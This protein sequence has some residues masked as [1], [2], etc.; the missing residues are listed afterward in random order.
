MPITEER[1]LP[2]LTEEAY[3]IRTELDVPHVYAKSMTDLALVQGFVMAQDR[4]VQIELTRR[5]GAGTL[6][7]LLGD[8]GLSI[9]YTSRAQGM[10]EISQRIWDHASPELRARFEAFAAG[11]NLYIDE[12]RRKR[13]PLPEEVELVGG[14]VGLDEPRDV[15]QPLTGFD[16]AA[17]AGVIV[18]RLGY[19]STDLDRERIEDA[20]EA[21]TSSTL[22]IALADLRRAGLR[23]DLVHSVRPVIP[24][25]S[26]E[27]GVRKT[28]SGLSP[29]NTP[30]G[31]IA[32]KKIEPMTLQRALDSS[33]TLLKLL[34]KSERG[35][36]GSNSWAV[37]SKGTGGKGA[38][39]SNDGHLPLTV[40]SLF[41]QMCLDSDYF[42]DTGYSVCGLFFPGLPLLAVGTN[43]KVAWGQ[44]YLDADL[45]DWYRE[46]V[47]IG[48]DGYPEA[49][50]FMGEW[51]PVTRKEEEYRV[52]NDDE[53]FDIVVQPLFSTFDGR[54]F[55][56]IE[57]DVVE[58]AEG[59]AVV[60]SNGNYVLPRD[61]DGDMKIEA[62]T[63]DWTA[64]DITK[65]I[66]GV[67][68]FANSS[69]VDEFI[70]QTRKL[71]GYGQNVIVADAQGGI[72]YTA[73]HG[74]PCRTALERSGNNFVRG[75]NP[76]QVLDGTRI[77]GFEIPSDAD[78]RI[79]EDGACVIPFTAGPRAITPDAGY[80]LTANH[81]PL[82]NAIDD[83]LANDQFYIGGPWDVG[84]RANTIDTKLGELASS[85][86]A[87]VEA[88]S[89]LQGDHTS[90]LGKEY[91]PVLLAAIANAKTVSERGPSGPD[92]TR[93]AAIYTRL[94]ARAADVTTR[95]TTWVSRGANAASGVE[96][97]YDAPTADDKKDAVATMI[98][99]EWLRA[100]VDATFID[101]NA[102]FAFGPSRGE[103]TYRALHHLVAGRGA[104][105]PSGLASWNM[106]TQESAFFDKLGTPEVERSE[107]II[108]EALETALDRLAGADGF[109]SADMDQWLWGLKHHVRF[110]ALL[111]EVAP[112]NPLAGILAF[113]F[114]INTRTLPL[115]ENIPAGDP[116][117]ALENFPR[118]GDFFSVDVAAGGFSGPYT[119]SHGPV[120]RMVIALDG[121]SVSGV[122]MLP[123]GQSG[124]AGNEHFADQAAMWLANETVPIRYH[125]AD[126]VDGAAGNEK[127][128]P[129]K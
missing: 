15:M 78:G 52:P 115:A 109:N 107:E 92:E 44:T 111:E 83:S 3:V 53:G 25:T 87:T 8:L 62:I 127:M 94:G 104:N 119:Y 124:L 97:F 17:V 49:T 96:T 58:A 34:G 93:L 91:A 4:Y 63:M 23:E 10:R 55:I 56:S 76:M 35:E 43:G 39:L 95:L 47:K 118:P 112:G 29:E 42:G 125:A 54:R 45:T 18:S 75:S 69:N 5:F 13:F 37:S 30:E 2:G 24:L 126:V 85:G 26:V 121:D 71:I 84:Y 65:T 129:P 19:E 117:A 74:L 9:D 105:N 128:T 116:R 68:G 64:L 103:K 32:R 89:A 79:R 11:V 77:G 28:G 36:F 82:G 48:A 57:G 70:E 31:A 51:K 21:A 12:V 60:L 86:S 88:M 106:E 113:K 120:M 27:P 38:L 61:V 80:V 72:A 108:L 99:A 90:P 98:H 41:Y 14:F 102:D 114:A 33:M 50:Y 59:R 46:E 6:S 110:K 81:D 20:L 100:F 67:D 73:Y 1:A 66:E 22:A 16:I 7:E 40:P 122:N 123:G 101:E